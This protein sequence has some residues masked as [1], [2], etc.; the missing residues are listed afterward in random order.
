MGIESLNHRIIESFQE[1]PAPL[2]ADSRL[3]D[4]VI[5]DD[6]SGDKD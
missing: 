2:V 1:T 4:S 3:N 5:L 6:R